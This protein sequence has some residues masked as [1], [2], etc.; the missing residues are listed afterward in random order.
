MFGIFCITDDWLILYII[1]RRRGCGRTRL[2][3]G[4]ILDARNRRGRRMIEIAQNKEF[5]GFNLSDKG[6]VLASQLLWIKRFLEE[7]LRHCSGDIVAKTC[8]N[9]RT[10]ASSKKSCRESCL[11]Y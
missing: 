9:L 5:R 8:I 7:Y 6:F 1:L 2:D 10:L 4:L 11:R 3:I